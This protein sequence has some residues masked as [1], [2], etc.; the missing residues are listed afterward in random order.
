MN[1]GELPAISE[2]AISASVSEVSP[3]V[4]AAAFKGML[5]LRDPAPLLA[6]FFAQLHEAVV[7]RGGGQV[8][9]DLRD[10]K[11]MNS[12]SFKQFVSWIRACSTAPAARRYKIHFVLS[13]LCYWQQASIQAL[14]CFADQ[15]VTYQL[16]E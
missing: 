13:S 8:R 9:V 1:T 2:K 4:V 12:A 7:A 3:G 6:P 15:L 14:L 10:L 5:T 11:F 16:D